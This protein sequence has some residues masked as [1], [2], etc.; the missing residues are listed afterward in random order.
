MTLA[1]EREHTMYRSL[2]PLAGAVVADPEPTQ[3]RLV[4]GCIAMPFIMYPTFSQSKCPPIKYLSFRAQVYP[5]GS[6]YP[7]ERKKYL[8]SIL[9]A[10]F[11]V[12]STQYTQRTTA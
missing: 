4:R 9:N 5:P 1:M 6:K 8:G 10:H 7:S 12:Y 2:L 11:T 3:V